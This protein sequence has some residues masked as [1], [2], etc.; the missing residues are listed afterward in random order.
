MQLTNN[1]EE[2]KVIKYLILGA[3]AIAAIVLVREFFLK[4]KP[5]VLP[6]FSKP[7][8]EI[9]IDFNVLDGSS[10]GQLKSFDALSLPSELGRDNPFA[11]F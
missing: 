3:A 10:I 8:S 11:P 6:E 1:K 4:P 7:F 9:K 5:L 2:D